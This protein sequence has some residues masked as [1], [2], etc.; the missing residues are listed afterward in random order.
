MNVNNENWNCKFNRM[1][2]IHQKVLSVSKV[3][4]FFKTLIEI[5]E[6]ILLYIGKINWLRVIHTQT[7]VCI[8]M[9]MFL[10]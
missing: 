4:Q 9:Y 2:F 1:N 6:T 10:K 7:R 8:Y 5:F 3:I